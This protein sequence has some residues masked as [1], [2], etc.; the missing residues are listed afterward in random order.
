M[1]AHLGCDGRPQVGEDQAHHRRDLLEGGTDRGGDLVRRHLV[2]A[3]AR[4][5]RLGHGHGGAD[6]DLQTLGLVTRE[7]EACGDGGIER[8]A[9]D[10]RRERGQR[11]R[12]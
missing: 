4:G 8:P 6:L 3:H 5:Q 12:A 11:A 2:G 7:P 9:A 10:V 1:I